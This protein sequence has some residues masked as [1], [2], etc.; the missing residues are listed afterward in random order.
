MGQGQTE[1]ALEKLH[2]AAEKG[3]WVCLKNLH[4][5]TFWLPTL[6]KEIQTLNQHE[7]FRLW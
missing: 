2:K 3:E 6:Q 5:M 4:L 7:N 1:V